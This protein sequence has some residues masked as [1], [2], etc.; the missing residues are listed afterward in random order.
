[1]KTK[2]TKRYLE[3]TPSGKRLVRRRIHAKKDR[4]GSL[5]AI[6]ILLGLMAGCLYLDKFGQVT[7]TFIVRAL[8]SPAPQAEDK[9][10]DVAIT[11]AQ[12]AEGGAGQTLTPETSLTEK[13]QIMIYIVTKFGDRSHQAIAMLAK[14]ENSELDPYATNHNRNGTIDRGI[15][16]INSIHGGEEMFDWKT[17]IDKAYEIY[18]AHDNT[19]YAWSCGDV[20]GDYTYKMKLQGK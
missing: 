17:N 12:Q 3:S 5:I 15:F 9:G 18:S 20:A 19:F 11:T 6:S 10:L 13:Q 1:M 2:Y 16:Q 4:S 14:C 7:T 8:E